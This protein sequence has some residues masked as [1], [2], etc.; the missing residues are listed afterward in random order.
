MEINIALAT[1]LAVLVG[2]I[3]DAIRLAVDPPSRW[4]PVVA[5]AVGAVGGGVA[6]AQTGAIV[7]GVVA[8]VAAGAMAAGIWPGTKAILRR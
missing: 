2:V 1:V 7:D 8:G 5:L 6:G 4:I 3:V